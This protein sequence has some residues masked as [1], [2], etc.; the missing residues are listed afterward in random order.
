MVTDD[1]GRTGSTSKLLS[2]TGAVSSQ[3]FALD[4]FARTRLTGWGAADVGG[5]WS[6]SA[7]ANSSVGAGVGNLMVNLGQTNTA[8]LPVSS[9]D[10]DLQATFTVDKVPTG[11]GVYMSFIGRRVGVG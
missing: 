2:A 6:I 8:L 1:L 11:S 9:S 3:P 4:T 10:S 7:S 5:T